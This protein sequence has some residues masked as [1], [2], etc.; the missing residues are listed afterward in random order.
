MD[1]RMDQRMGQGFL[2]NSGDRARPRRLRHLLVS[3]AQALLIVLAWAPERPRAESAQGDPP[4]ECANPKAKAFLLSAFELQ[5]DHNTDEALAKYKKCLELDPSC[6]SCLYEIGWSHW[7]LGEWQNVIATWEAALKLDPKHAKVLE[8]LP[9]AKE[10]LKI[11]EAKNKVE[12]FR[13][14]TDIFVESSPKDAPVSMTFISRWQAY[15]PK[16]PSP[17][18]HFDRDIDSP[19]SASFSPDGK[20]IYVNSLEGGKTVVFDALGT[21]KRGVVQHKFDGTEKFID[22]KPPFDYSWPAKIK[23]P[24]KFSGKPVESV[25]SHGG[26]FLW[27]PYYRRNFDENGSAPAAMA[28]VDADNLRIVRVVGTG[29]IAKYVQVSPD[30]HFLAVSHWG[31]NT[32][33]LFDI[34]AKQPADFKE[35]AKLVVDKPLSK[36]EM[37]GNRDKNCG[38]CLRGLAYSKD[39][40]YLFVAR[41]RKGGIAIFDLEAKPKPR[42]LGTVFGLDPGPRDLQ[43]SADGEFLYSGS[44]ASGFIVEV[45]VQAL[46]E[47][48]QNKSTGAA[49]TV[50]PEEIG[51]R[52]VFAGTGVRS[53]K[54]TTDGKY[55]FAAVNKISELHVYSTKEMKRISKIPVDSYPVGL[56]LSPD[57]RQAW[58]TSQGNGL[59]GGNSVGVYRVQYRESEDISLSK[60]P[61]KDVSIAPK[62]KEP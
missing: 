37:V 40:R 49:V 44:N 50:T 24:N 4:L 26:K 35:V 58:V 45:R 34:R 7:K 16:S 62:E 51:A 52:K 61:R 28:I 3:V 13:S 57:G 59:K 54:L 17:L 22:K 47:Q 41:M 25:S 8:Y 19:K 6:V 9:T 53:I 33:G 14:K 60:D 27:V 38:F 48:F 55:L 39:S 1:R 10:N 20:K 31:D 43:I 42:Y 29:P 36:K 12:V 23:A 30:G 21:E 2:K 5:K 15:N 11:V 56:A 46:L 18:D 32:V